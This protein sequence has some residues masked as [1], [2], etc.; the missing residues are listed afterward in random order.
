M[1]QAEL[2]IGM[3]ETTS[4][5]NHL[6]GGD[7]SM[8]RYARAAGALYLVIIV[9]G[10]LG[11]AWIRGSLVV[12]GDAAATAQ[13]ILASQFLWRLGVAGELVL[14]VCAVALTFLWYVLLRPVN[15]NLALL[16]VF[17]AMMSLAVEAVSALYLQAALTPLSSAA[18]LG[19][20]DL[21][22]RY[23]MAYMAVVSH[24]RA[25]GMALIFFGVECLI[26]GHLICQSGYFPR[27]IG[28]LMQIAGLCYLVNSFAL[29]LSPSLASLLFPAILLPALIGEGSFC[30]WLLIKGVDIAG[31]AG[32][33]NP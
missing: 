31:W 4:G 26:V 27:V 14:L 18:Y 11:E 25:F 8:H 10:L 19:V 17:F 16:M 13:R 22:Q 6:Q 12:S 9:I 24:G 28:R 23:A 32:K 2:T 3:P 7:G 20:I 29:I 1:K 33:A 5:R 15:R 30:L 21:Q